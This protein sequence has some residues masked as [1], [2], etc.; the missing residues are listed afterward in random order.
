LSVT[1]FLSES[2]LLSL[3]LLLLLLLLLY[4]SF[5]DT[6]GLRVPTEQ[7][8]DFSHFNFSNVSRLSLQQIASRL[9][10]TSADFWTFSV[11]ITSPLSIHFPRL[12]LLRYIITL[13]PLL[14]YCLGLYFS[15]VLIVAQTASVV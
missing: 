3:F 6:V 11:N 1:F 9:Q 5:T 10:T 8:G 14:F 7:I 12:N 13:L 2:V 15:L 4:C